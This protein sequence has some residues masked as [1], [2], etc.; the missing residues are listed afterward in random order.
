MNA[1]NMSTVVGRE[2]ELAAVRDFLERIADGPA[3]LVLTGE[4]GI[5]KTTVWRAGVE[6]AVDR[7]CTVLRCRPAATDFRLSHASLAD[8]L[9]EVAPAHFDPLPDPQRRAL[10]AALLRTAAADS[11]PD[12]RAVAAGLLSV[13]N[14]PSRDAP[15]IV[16]IDDFQ[17]LDAPSRDAIEFAVRRCHGSVGV[18][19]AERA[20]E[21][22]QGAAALV[23]RDPK[24]RHVVALGPLSLDALHHVIRQ[25]TGRSIARP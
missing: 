9:A 4:P 2:S 3:M 11:S 21:T 6:A 19:I 13:I 18:L 17:W 20:S 8:L 14:A 1:G 7:G 10:D 12:P 5:G 24:R 22:T 25:G 23:P 15:V 16:A